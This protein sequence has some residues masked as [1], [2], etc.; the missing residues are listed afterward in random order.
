MSLYLETSP[1][2]GKDKAAE[3]CGLD[4][5][6]GA[7]VLLQI[8]AGETKKWPFK[9]LP[10]RIKG[11]QNGIGVWVLQSIVGTSQKEASWN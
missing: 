5:A 11:S 1:R 7:G 4:P 8:L 3:L 6:W 10:L 9:N 2:E